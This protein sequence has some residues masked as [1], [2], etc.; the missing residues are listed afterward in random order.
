MVGENQLDLSISIRSDRLGSGIKLLQVGSGK[1]F[2]W[3]QS[4]LRRIECSGVYQKISSIRSMRESI[5]SRVNLSGEWD[6]GMKW[7]SQG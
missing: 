7:L 4:L 3:V 1:S 6:I 5:S 2:S